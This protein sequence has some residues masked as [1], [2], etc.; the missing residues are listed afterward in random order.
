MYQKINPEILLDVY[1]RLKILYDIIK[2]NNKP[3]IPMDLFCSYQKIFTNCSDKNI[4]DFLER[5]LFLNNSSILLFNNK[6]ETFFPFKIFAFQSDQIDEFLNNCTYTENIQFNLL[7][8]LIQIFFDKM[9]P[10]NF[11]YNLAILNEE[12]LNLCKKIKANTSNKVKLQDLALL[13]TMKKEIYLMW[14]K[15]QKQNKNSNKISKEEIQKIIS[16]I[17]KS[18]FNHSGIMI[19]TIIYGKIFSKLPTCT[20]FN[21]LPIFSD[22]E[23]QQNYIATIIKNFNDMIEHY[24]RN[25]KTNSEAKTSD[26]KVSDLLM[27]TKRNL[28]FTKNSIA[29][30]FTILLRSNQN[31]LKQ[32]FPQEV[33]VFNNHNSEIIYLMEFISTHFG[34]S[35]E[36]TVELYT[37]KEEQKRF[38]HKLFAMK[39]LL[40]S[41]IQQKYNKKNKTIEK[42][43]LFD[44]FIELQTFIDH[45]Y[46]YDEGFCQFV[47]ELLYGFYL[48]ENLKAKLHAH[49]NSRLVNYTNFIKQNIKDDISVT[50]SINKNAPKISIKLEQNEEYKEENLENED[51]IHNLP[52]KQ[53]TFTFNEKSQI[54]Q[55][56]HMNM[57]QSH[58]VPSTKAE[59]QLLKEK[60][61][62]LFANELSKFSFSKNN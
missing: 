57:I 49:I 48:H 13:D 24:E 27:K 10:Y 15:L 32:L 9:G 3:L 35:F 62:A 53:N 4:Q 51:Q 20:F 61:D 5:L 37:H 44:Y 26:T 16:E 29:A 1:D 34:Y 12:I 22:L 41:Q 2:K 17:I 58:Y 52:E 40:L 23:Q 50:S 42:L 45:D 47:N 19:G 39:N 36:Y 25:L 54:H 38:L 11:K 43:E 14:V 46:Q 28:N 30:I 55:H 31:I 21:S 18:F 8:R 59:K 33:Y 60:Q 6:N 56:V 7:E